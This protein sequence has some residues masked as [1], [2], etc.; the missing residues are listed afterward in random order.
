MIF[1]SDIDRLADASEGRI[2]VSGNDEGIVEFTNP[3]AE[4]MFGYSFGGMLNK[5]VELL[6]P[7][8]FREA[9]KG[10]R[11]MYNLDPQ[12][13]PMGVSRPLFG[14]RKDGKEFR[15]TV[16]L[17]PATFALKEYVLAIITELTMP[18]ET[19]AGSGTAIATVSASP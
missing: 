18:N 7:I 12:I 6:L 2:L 3:K 11:K 10:F 1:P 4:S 16:T 17:T 15:I 19:P 8:R 14:L 9:H 5:P 13:R